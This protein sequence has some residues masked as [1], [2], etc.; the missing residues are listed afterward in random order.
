MLLGSARSADTSIQSSL[1]D[2]Y[3]SHKV[4]ICPLYFNITVSVLSMSSFV[5]IILVNV[6][7]E[8]PSLDCGVC[9]A[10]TRPILSVACPHPQSSVPFSV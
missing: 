5:I 4:L 9:A 7:I 2:G 10:R 6:K 1:H 3:L 8:G